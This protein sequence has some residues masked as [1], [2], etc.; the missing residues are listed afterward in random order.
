[1]DEYKKDLEKVFLDY[2]EI[3]LTVNNMLEVITLLTQKMNLYLMDYRFRDFGKLRTGFLSLEI[4][5]GNKNTT[6][7]CDNGKT[8]EE[9]VTEMN[10]QSWNELNQTYNNLPMNNDELGTP[11]VLEK[12]SMNRKAIEQIRNRDQSITSEV[13]NEHLY[14]QNE[15]EL[16]DKSEPSEL[17]E[18]RGKKPKSSQTKKEKITKFDLSIAGYVYSENPNRRELVERVIQILEESKTKDTQREQIIYIRENLPDW[19]YYHLDDMLRLSHGYVRVQVTSSGNPDGRPPKYGQELEGAV[20]RVI[21]TFGLHK[22]PR[23]GAIYQ[24]LKKL[25][26]FSDLKMSYLR[27]FIYNNSNIFETVE[28]E[29]REKNRVF[30]NYDDIKKYLESLKEIEDIPVEFVYNMD[31]SGYQNFVDAITGKVVL[32]KGQYDGECFI[33]DGKKKYL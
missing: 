6:T 27:K 23:M 15:S 32:V 28:I 31:E 18:E 29:N 19:S 11:S 30:V 33:V 20:K 8:V 9:K 16:G 12:V 25:P 17:L 22:K 1:M 10:E 13:L 14:A 21:G 4:R 3:K 2:I 5:N 26:E 24:E 7:N